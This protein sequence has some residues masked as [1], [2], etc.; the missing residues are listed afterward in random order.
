MPHPLAPNEEEHRLKEETV[1]AEQEHSAGT[2]LFLNRAIAQDTAM[3]PDAAREDLRVPCKE[4]NE[5][6]CC[7]L[8]ICNRIRQ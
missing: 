5:F 2:D 8:R 4:W 6:R 7:M 1:D 3:R